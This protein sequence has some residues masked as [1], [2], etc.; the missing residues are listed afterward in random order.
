MRPALAGPVLHRLEGQGLHGLGAVPVTDRPAQAPA[1]AAHRLDR[2]GELE[3]MRAGAA[4]P[5][6]GRER[7]APGREVRRRGGQRQGEDRRILLRSP[8]ALA[9]RHDGGD[10]AGAVLRDAPLHR[11]R[12]R[13]GQ[14]ARARVVR[15]ALGAEDQEAVEPR[16]VADRE[17][18][19]SGGVRHR[20][21]DRLRLR[22]GAE[23]E[24]LCE[25]RHGGLLS[26]SPL[27]IAADRRPVARP[28][29]RGRAGTRPRRV[30]HRRSRAAGISCGRGR[31]S[32]RPGAGVA[33]TKGLSDALLERRA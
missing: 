8:A 30:V 9:H 15:A 19:A 28:G 20:A 1:P 33:A 31:G 32:V 27:S 3:Q 6:Q 12:V 4:D 24:H 2:G 14:G 16:P 18:V 23:P 10:R 17:G 11:R 21:G 5:R 13:G 25:L 29:A 26:V 7:R 22:G